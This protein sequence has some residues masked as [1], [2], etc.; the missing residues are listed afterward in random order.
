MVGD[1]DLLARAA[2]LFKDRCATVVELANWTEMLFVPVQPSDADRAT[3]ITEALVPA[4]RALRDK[5][6]E[7][8][9]DKTAIAAVMKE[10]LAAHQVK[11]GQLAPAACVLVCGRAQTPSLDATLALFSRQT[12]LDRLRSIMKKWAIV[13]D[14]LERTAVLE[15]R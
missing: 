15:L 12:V 4:L 3:H 6:A 9:W 13:V 5:L 2:A 14:S 8:A 7:V 1:L 11:M 10:V